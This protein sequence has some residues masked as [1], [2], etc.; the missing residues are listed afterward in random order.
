MTVSPSSPHSTPVGSQV[1]FECIATGD[2]LPS[3]RWILPTKSSSRSSA[4]FVEVAPGLARLVI[5]QVTFEDQGIYKCL[6]SNIVGNIEERVSLAGKKNVINVKFLCFIL[7]T[8]Y[9][10]I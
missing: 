1:I 2:P 3:V 7:Y 5:E 4:E 9:F 8:C 10:D 6:A